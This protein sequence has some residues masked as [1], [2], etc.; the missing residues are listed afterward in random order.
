[1]DLTQLIQWSD[2]EKTCTALIG[3]YARMGWCIDESE[4]RSM[5]H[6]I[7]MECR[8]K[9]DASRG[10]KFG[11]Y[12]HIALRNGFLRHLNEMK[13]WVPLDAV[14]AEALPAKDTAPYADLCYKSLLADMTPDAREFVDAIMSAARDG[15]TP[16]SICRRASRFCQSMGWSRGKLKAAKKGIS[17]ALNGIA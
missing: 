6:F 13:R 1:M 8:A 5:G 4:M 12:Y 10:V 2:Y 14:T 15:G 17:A 16:S 3:R 11:Y 7:F 9:W